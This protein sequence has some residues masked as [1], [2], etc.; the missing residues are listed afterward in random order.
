MPGIKKLRE[1]LDRYPEIKYESTDLSI[2]I[3]PK[4]E[5]EFEVQLIISADDVAV[6]YD[7]WHREFKTIEEA[8]PWFFNGLTV[9]YRLK[10]SARGDYKYK[11]ELEI[12]KD[13]RWTKSWVI[14]LFVYPFWRRNRTF[15]L[16][17]CYFESEASVSEIIKLYNS[18]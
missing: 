8:L 7:G 12:Q 18:D 16:Q 13:D 2:S 15:Y 9:F 6:H 1:V 17:N 4:D 5:S 11:W 14:A 10:V 3:P